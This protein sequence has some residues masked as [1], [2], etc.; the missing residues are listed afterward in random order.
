MADIVTEQFHQSLRSSPSGRQKT[1]T[2][3]DE[4]YGAMETSENPLDRV[5][6]MITECHGPWSGGSTELF[7]FASFVASLL[8]IP[9]ATLVALNAGESAC[10]VERAIAITPPSAVGRQNTQTKNE[11]HISHQTTTTQ[12]T[13]DYL[14]HLLTYYNYSL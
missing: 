8:N 13:F 14:L 11:I 1:G 4:I 12:Q 9:A 7:K 10:V 5:V 3:I 6:Q 2:M